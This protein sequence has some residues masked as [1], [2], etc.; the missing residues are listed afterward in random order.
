MRFYQFVLRN[1]FRRRMRSALTIIGVAVALGAVVSLVGISD[2]FKKSFVSMYQQNDVDLIVSDPTVLNPLMGNMP[3]EMNAKI[4]GLDGV[5]GVAA[6]LVDMVSF[7]DK[8][9][10]NVIVQGWAPDSFMFEE[11]RRKI[12]DPPAVGGKRPATGRRR[13]ARD[14]ARV[15]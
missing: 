6:G 13:T 5:A 11:I 2:G 12:V 8:G 9:L 10:F 7:E 3:E 14:P 4:R 15:C 1:V